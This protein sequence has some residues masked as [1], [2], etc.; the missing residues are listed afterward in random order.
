LI[1]KGGTEI[2]IA[3]V[4]QTGSRLTLALPTISGSY[5]GE[6]KDGVLTGK[7]TQGPNTRP[8]VFKKQERR[9][10]NRFRDQTLE[11]RLPR[12]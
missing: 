3:S 6:L 8:L 9:G 2:P 12:T 11:Q 5:D 7:W 4:V 10:A 1:G